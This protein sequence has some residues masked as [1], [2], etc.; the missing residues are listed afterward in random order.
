MTSP[1]HSSHSSHAPNSDAPA[2]ALHYQTQIAIVG[3]GP[4]GL[5]AADT[6]QRAGFRVILFD[7]GVIA[8]PMLDYPT[9]MTWFSTA[10]L[11]ELGGM[12]L[13]VGG[14]KPTR[15]EYLAYLRRFVSERRL[16]VRVGH[17][18]RSLAG[19][20]GAFILRGVTRLGEPWECAAA[21]VVFAAG[22]FGTPRALGVPGENLPHVSHYYKE[23]HAHYG[24]KVLVV[25]GRN[26]AVEA[27]LELWRAGV[28]VSVCHRAERFRS[29][30]Y[31]LEP[32]IENRI[33]AGRIK[34]YRPARVLEIRPRSVVLQIGDDD[35]ASRPI[36]I[37]ADQVLALTGHIPDPALL[38]R[39]GVAPPAGA[40]GPAYDPESLESSRPGLYIV[41]VALAGNVG[42]EIF[43]ENSRTHGD[44]VLAHLRR[45][46]LT[47]AAS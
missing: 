32:D 41:G 46:G 24:S 16:D 3:A 44:R 8:E 29:L 43:I 6:L 28:E 34:A 31:W 15:K 7:K 4:S 13:T 27:A 18:A 40:E 26:S 19:S 36:E 10:D 42:G 45:A 37:E 47:G 22:A 12:P 21:K 38:A 30:K 33:G 14:D 23:P 11:L 20:D 35:S 9:Y 17:E 2:P 5:A 25:G 1:S 39:F